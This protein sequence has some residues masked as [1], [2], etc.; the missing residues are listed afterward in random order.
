MNRESIARE[1][2]HS[3]GEKFVLSHPDDLRVYSY[4][5]SNNM[6]APNFVIPE[7][8]EQISRVVKFAGKMVS[9]S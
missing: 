4:D 8:A 1:I 7:N 2:A 9:P 6:L 3:V 5:A